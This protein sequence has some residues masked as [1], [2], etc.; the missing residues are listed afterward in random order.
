M[1][2]AITQSQAHA[3]PL[4]RIQG[5]NVRLNGLVVTAL[6]AAGVYFAMDK[7]KGGAMRRGA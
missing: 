5:V 2:G 4:F 1:H 6:V 3:F 7:V